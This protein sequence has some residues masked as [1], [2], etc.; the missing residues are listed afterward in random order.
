MSIVFCFLLSAFC[1]LY[2]VWLPRGF[3]TWEV[4]GTRLTVL[5]SLAPVAPRGLTRKPAWQCPLPPPRPEVVVQPVD[6]ELPEKRPIA[7]LPD[8]REKQP[9]A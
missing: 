8:L 5:S 4:Q 2:R 1:L 7:Q 3:W 9:K 6:T